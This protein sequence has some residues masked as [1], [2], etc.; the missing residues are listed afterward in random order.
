M[1]SAEEHLQAL[2]LD[3]KYCFT[4]ELQIL[5]KKIKIDNISYPSHKDELRMHEE[6]EAI[7][8]PR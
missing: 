7:T 2:I 6:F 4:I 5:Y 8:L 1:T 3:F